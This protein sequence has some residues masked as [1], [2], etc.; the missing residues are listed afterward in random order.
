[1]RQLHAANVGETSQILRRENGAHAGDAPAQADRPGFLRQHVEQL[2]RSRMTDEFCDR[3]RG[4][5][6]IGRI[7][8]RDMRDARAEL[9]GLNK[10]HVKRAG[11]QLLHHR[12]FV[13]EL[14]GVKHGHGQAAIGGGLQ[15]FAELERGLVPGMPIRGDES[16]P[17]LLGLGL[18]ERG[19]EQRHGRAR[20]RN[21]RREIVMA[22]F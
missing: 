1:M 13:A 4:A 15:V 16:E 9:G 5:N 22:R 17:E 12:R 11:L 8:R 10:S 18:C 6:D 20:G 19:R 21:R 2:D 3:R 14:A 7:D